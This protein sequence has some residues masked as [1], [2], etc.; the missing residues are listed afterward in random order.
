MPSVNKP[1][2][3]KPI[4]KEPSAPKTP[5]KI[6]KPFPPSSAWKK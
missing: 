1:L 6:P 5:I 2:P 3:P 4:L